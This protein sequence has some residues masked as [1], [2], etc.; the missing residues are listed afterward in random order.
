MV[1]NIVKVE[2]L[3]LKR[4]FSYR[5]DRTVDKLWK[6]VSTITIDVQT[7]SLNNL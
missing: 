7:D 4:F 2:F 5:I 6:I 1:T 3:N